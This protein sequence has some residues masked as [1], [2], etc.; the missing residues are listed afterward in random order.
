MLRHFE[1]VRQG[2]KTT[3]LEK[4]VFFVL[5]LSG[6]T[7]ALHVLTIGASALLVQNGTCDGTIWDL[8]CMAY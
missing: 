4:F 5:F 7:L 3:L 8:L 6:Q 2:K 1:A